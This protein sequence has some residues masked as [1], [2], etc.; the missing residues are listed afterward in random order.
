MS[1]PGSF[2]E[3]DKR[4]VRAQMQEK[5]PLTWGYMSYETVRRYAQLISAMVILSIPWATAGTRS[6]TT[7]SDENMTQ[8]I[9]KMQQDTVEVIGT[10]TVPTP[11]KQ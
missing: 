3:F 11:I 1:S 5:Y 8:K 2:H 10:I 6:H 4:C 9:R 7:S